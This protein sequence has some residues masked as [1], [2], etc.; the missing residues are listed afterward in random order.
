[1]SLATW[2]ISARF[3][4]SGEDVGE[5]ELKPSD[6]VSELSLAIGRLANDGK[7]M[8]ILFREQALKGA[9]TL[10]AAGLADG[11]VVDVVKGGLAGWTRICH[12]DQ[13]GKETT[14]KPLIWDLPIEDVQRL[15]EKA[16]RVRIQQRN[17]PQ[18]AVES[19]PGSYPIENI[20]RGNPIGYRHAL[21]KARVEETWLVP[22]GADPSSV[23]TRLWHTPYN[24][25][26]TGGCS[27]CAIRLIQDNDLVWK[28]E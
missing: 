19:K 12:G 6:T 13:N 16:T 10:E 17:N 2:K 22:D 1:M 7:P 5:V 3:L 25:S 26:R 27:I 24:N 14:G 20:R 15:A 4:V 8:R 9:S 21:E 23:P 28:P 11:S 18:L